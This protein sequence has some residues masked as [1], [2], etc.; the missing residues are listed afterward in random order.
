MQQIE[1]SYKMVYINLT[2]LIIPINLSD[3]NTAIERQTFSDQIRRCSTKNKKSINSDR[4]KIKG[5]IKTYYANTNQKRRICS[6]YCLIQNSD[7]PF[8]LLML[9]KSY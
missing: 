3:L 9:G 7:I 8:L 4:L 5:L 2:I 6:Y 1:N